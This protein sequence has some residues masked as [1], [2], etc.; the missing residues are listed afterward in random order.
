MDVEIGHTS[1]VIYARLKG[2]E[3]K[4]FL[5]YHVENGSMILL[6]TYTPPAFRGKALLSV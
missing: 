1:S 3:E 6:E 5:R 2:D 4:A